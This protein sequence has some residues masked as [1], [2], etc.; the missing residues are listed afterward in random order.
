MRR[1]AALLISTALCLTTSPAWAGGQIGT[2]LSGHRVTREQRRE[3][4]FQRVDRA[5]WTRHEIRLTV[6]AAVKQWPVPGGYDTALAIASCES[7][8]NPRAWNPNGYGG[9]WQFAMNYWPARQNNYDN[10]PR[11]DLTESVFNARTATVVAIRMAHSG[12]W[13]PW[14]CY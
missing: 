7:G 1:L 5:K 12:G 10:P 3:I 6:R 9:L 4:R 13:S 2:A 14:S 11:W 8:L